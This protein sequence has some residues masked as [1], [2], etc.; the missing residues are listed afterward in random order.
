MQLFY[1]RLFP[2][3]P[4]YL[5]LNQEQSKSCHHAGFDNEIDM[6]LVPSKLFTHREFAFTLAGDVYLRY[7]SFNNVDEFKVSI[8]RH[9]PSRFE[10]GPQ[11][12]A[13]VCSCL[14]YSVPRLT[15]DTAEGQED[16]C[17]WRSSATEA[18]ARF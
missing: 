7:Q 13:R 1:R 15:L 11:Y 5:W 3:R 16:A 18:R 4:L 6:D 9:I 8:A 2:Y 14:S 17:L 10:I 12:S